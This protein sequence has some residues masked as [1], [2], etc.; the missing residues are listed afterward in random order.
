MIKLCRFLQIHLKMRSIFARLLSMQLIW[1]RF[2]LSLISSLRIDWAGHSMRKYRTFSSSWGHT[3]HFR[4]DDASRETGVDSEH[5]FQYG[6]LRLK[7][8]SSSMNI[9]TCS[10]SKRVSLW[11]CSVGILGQRSTR[12]DNVAGHGPFNIL[13]RR[14]HPAVYLFPGSGGFC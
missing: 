5:I 14:W 7:S 11:S 2:D 9:G 10:L 8:P 1:D 6:V 3:W 13:D 12:L 4:L